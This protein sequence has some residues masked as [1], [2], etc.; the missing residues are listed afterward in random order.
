MPIGASMLARGGHT[1]AMYA[2]MAFL[3]IIGSGVS[4]AFSA[5]PFFLLPGPRLT[6]GQRR[7][8]CS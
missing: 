8:S 6:A 1:A 7:R 5:P 3:M 2:F 4:I